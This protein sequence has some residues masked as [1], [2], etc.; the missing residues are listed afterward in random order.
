M[1]TPMQEM[2][3]EMNKIL[4]EEKECFILDL[5]DKARELLKKEREVIMDAYEYGFSDAKSNH[6]HNKLILQRNL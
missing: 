6:D 2:I 5:R 3:D 4:R 1:K